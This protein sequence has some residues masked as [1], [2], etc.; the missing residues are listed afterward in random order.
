M[1]KLVKIKLKN[2]DKLH[3]VDE[4][5]AS[6]KRLKD[7]ANHYVE[8]LKSEGYGDFKPAI[9]SNIY[10]AYIE[11]LGIFINGKDS[12]IE[13]SDFNSAKL[14][15]GRYYQPLKKS[16]SNKELTNNFEYCKAS[17]APLLELIFGDTQTLTVDE[18]RT[19]RY[20]PLSTKYDNGVFIAVIDERD[21]N[22][23]TLENFEVI[24]D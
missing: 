8:K 12:E 17:F 18:D 11:F 16:K 22:G 5:E 10:E 6:T 21:I 20:K 9:Q 19:T 2:L 15:N 14:K 7:I 1:S 3:I 24:N 13:H 4:H 23:H